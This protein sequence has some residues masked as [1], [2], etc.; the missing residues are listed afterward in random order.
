MISVDPSP[1][2]PVLQSSSSG[3]YQI[4]KHPYMQHVPGI[5]TNC[6]MT[7]CQTTRLHWHARD[8]D[9]C[10]REVIRVLEIPR[11]DRNATEISDTG[12]QSSIEASR[13]TP[14][15][16]HECPSSAAVK[17]GSWGNYTCPAESMSDETLNDDC[18]FFPEL[19]T[20]HTRRHA[21][22]Y[23]SEFPTVAVRS[24][25]STNDKAELIR[26]ITC[27]VCLQ[28]TRRR[29]PER[30]LGPFSGLEAGSSQDVPRAED[31]VV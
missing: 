19:E 28:A 18:L 7:F 11:V 6:S 31:R 3:L 30:D 25:R 14:G 12:C 23:D 17:P 1:S 24:S 2:D 29:S 16:I 5:A 21:Y 13:I 15:N 26:S 4:Q 27:R 20:C 10:C 9:A 8:S 22:E